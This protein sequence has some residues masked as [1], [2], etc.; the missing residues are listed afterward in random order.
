MST[1]AFLAGLT[2]QAARATERVRTL[3]GDDSYVLMSAFAL[4]LGITAY[5]WKG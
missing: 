2:Q 1:L 5:P 4:L 3:A